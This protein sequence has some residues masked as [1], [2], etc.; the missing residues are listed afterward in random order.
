M[1]EQ[2]SLLAVKPPEHSSEFERR[3]SVR[4]QCGR[5]ASCS[6]LAPIERLSGR[7]RDISMEGI[8]LVLGTSI[9]EG[10]EVVIDL[11]TRNPGIC[12]TLRAR[13]VHSTLEAEGAWIIGGEFITVP[14]EEQLQALL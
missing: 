5:E 6:S 2:A 9:R 13:V 8:A 14:S 11:K 4:Y 7:V 10:T 1:S 12:L 3:V